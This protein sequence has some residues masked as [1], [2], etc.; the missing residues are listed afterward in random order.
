MAFSDKMDTSL[1]PGTI[2]QVDLEG[3]IATEH[4]V[5]RLADVVLIPKPSSDPDDPLNV[6]ESSCCFQL[7]GLPHFGLEPC[8]FTLASYFSKGYIVLIQ[9]SGPRNAS[10][11][12]R[13]H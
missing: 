1:I 12:P 7:S 13:L 4:S 6:S 3:T 5:G 2:H 9:F 8:F 11:Y 10:Y